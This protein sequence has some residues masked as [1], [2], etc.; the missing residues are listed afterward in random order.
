[1]DPATKEEKLKWLKELVYSMY[2]FRTKYT[3]YIKAKEKKENTETLE[4][5]YNAADEKVATIEESGEGLGLD[6]SNL[7]RQIIDLTKENKNPE[8]IYLALR[9]KIE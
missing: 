7:N 2:D 3:A 6:I 4:T 1:M 5:E 9:E 8:E